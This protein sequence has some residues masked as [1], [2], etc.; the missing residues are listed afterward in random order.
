MKFACWLLILGVSS[1]AH[2]MK[3]EYYG[4]TTLP[5]STK[6]RKTTVGGL[7][8]LVYHGN[9]LW[10]AS[11]DKG[12]FGDPRF[13]IFNLKIQKDSVSL[14]PEAVHYI[15]D[16]PVPLRGEKSLLDLEGIVLLPNGDLI[17]SSENNN[18]KKPRVPPRLL[19]V[20]SKGKYKSDI[21]IPEKYI[22]EALGKQDKGLKNNAGFE[23]LTRTEDGKWIFAANEASLNTDE[24]VGA[25]GFEQGDRIRILKFDDKNQL[26]AEYA[27]QLDV[28]S[29]LGSG[30]E[31]FRG[32]SEI[33]AINESKLLVMERGVRLHKTGWTQTVAL[34][35]T[36]LKTAD[37]VIK[38]KN[39]SDTKLK[40]AHKVKVLDLETDLQHQ[41]PNK[42]LQNFEGLA[43]GPMLPNK[44]KSLLLISDNN[45]SKKE[46]TELLVFSV[47]GE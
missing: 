28:P 31:V 14:K 43:W 2:A 20:S 42:A 3:L 32:V 7:S 9:Q 26:A 25:E 16:I 40:F 12:K 29:K 6:Y 15:T 45:F 10:V 41:R 47:E 24:P 18:D 1:M 19:L 23:G 44:K 30:I 36:D 22:P 21:Q 13:Y 33:L 11:D 8:A 37:D 35:L 38:I 34:Y 27:Y 17:V 4:E 5:N 46:T 39:L